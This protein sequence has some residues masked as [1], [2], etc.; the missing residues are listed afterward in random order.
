MPLL[1]FARSL[2]PGFRK[3]LI[4]APAASALCHQNTLPWTGQIRDRLAILCVKYQ[5]SHRNPQKHVFAGMPRTVRSFA[6][7]SAIRFEL[8]VVSIPQQ[9]V[10]VRVRF[11]VDA[12]TVTAIS[13]RGSAPRHKLLPA[14]RNAPVPAVPRFHQNL[15]FIYKHSP[16]FLSKN[17]NISIRHCRK[18]RNLGGHGSC[19]VSV[20]GCVA[21]QFC[22][23]SSQFSSA[24]APT[25]FIS[26]ETPWPPPHR[27]LA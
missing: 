20:C 2:V 6:M 22:S 18:S 4:S 25:S 12:P 13:T 27:I 16:F 23:L 9:R 7:A 11:Q 3:I 21:P 15:C 24:S 1:M 17:D 10:V 19:L 26:I 8:S 5:R 14:E